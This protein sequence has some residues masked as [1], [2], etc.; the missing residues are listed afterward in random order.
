VQVQANAT[1]SRNKIIDFDE[2]IDDY[3]EGGQLVNHYSETD[4]AFSPEIIAGGLLHLNPSIAAFTTN[5]FCDLIGKYVGRQ[6]L[7]IL[8]IK[9]GAFILMPL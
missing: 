1:L 2:Y 4:I 6:Y 5:N 9:T 7:I 8:P 3:D